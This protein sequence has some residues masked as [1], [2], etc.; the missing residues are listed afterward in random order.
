M[1]FNPLWMQGSMN[2]INSQGLWYCCFLYG[3]TFINNMDRLYYS[4]FSIKWR[5]EKCHKEISLFSNYPMYYIWCL[6][7][8]SIVA[9]T[10]WRLLQIFH[11]EVASSTNLQYRHHGFLPQFLHSTSTDSVPKIHNVQWLIAWFLCHTVHISTSVEA[12][13]ECWTVALPSN[14]TRDWNWI[15][16]LRDRKFS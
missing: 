4:P 1:K 10:S 6:W 9:E 13:L 16:Y 14:T 7:S 11:L 5:P 15:I 12:I 2:D 3:W 8:R